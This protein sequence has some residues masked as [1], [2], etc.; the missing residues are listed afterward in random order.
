MNQTLGAPEPTSVPPE[1]TERLGGPVGRHA[2]RTGVWFN[3][4]VWAVLVAG[5]G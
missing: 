5:L 4:A 1:L 3:P 2:R